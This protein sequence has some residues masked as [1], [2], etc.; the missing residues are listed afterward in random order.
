M[1]SSAGKQT[2]IIRK[3]VDFLARRPV[4]EA[5]RSPHALVP[6]SMPAPI[7]PDGISHKLS[8]NYY[9]GRDPRRTAS[10]PV[11]VINATS[12]KALDAAETEVEVK[13]KAKGVRLPGFGYNIEGLGSYGKTK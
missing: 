5:L 6:R 11:Q 1:A 12:Q 4:K 7:L 2:P 10:P 9:E 3:L 13:S 8:A